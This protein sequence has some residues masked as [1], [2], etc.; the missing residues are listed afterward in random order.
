MIAYLCGKTIE[1]QEGRIVL[2]MQQGDNPKHLVGYQIYTPTS[3]Q[4]LQTIL[5]ETKEFFIYTHIREDQ[6]D[7][8]GFMTALEK[9]IFLTLLTV[10]GIGPKGALSLLSKVELPYLVS[11]IL[12]EDKES[13][14]K[15]PGIGKKT[16]ERVVVELA[17]AIHKKIENGLLPREWMKGSSEHV[18][19]Q[20]ISYSKI[21]PSP[22]KDA[23]SALVGLGYKEGEALSI[24]QKI[25]DSIS[26]TPT[27]ADEFIKLA[28]KNISS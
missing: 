5:S 17:D 23:L 11:A 8:Y 3:P 26:P 19:T 22:L 7:L 10:N 4:Y 13:L 27:K 24:L 1:V 14:Q 20:N 9:E 28:L 18:Q 16:A 21:P 15:I 25:Q 2:G 12:N 6:F